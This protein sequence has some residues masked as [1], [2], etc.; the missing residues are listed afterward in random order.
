MLFMALQAFQMVPEL[1]Y[2][3]APHPRWLASELQGWSSVRCS[4]PCI[5]CSAGSGKSSA[6]RLIFR[7]YD[8]TSGAVYM[9]GQNVAD[10][11]QASLRTHMGFVPQ[12]SVLFNDTILHNIRCAPNVTP[13]PSGHCLCQEFAHCRDARGPSAQQ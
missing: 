7:F 8:P 2:L 5:T 1:W 12:D 3:A 6:L 9:D 10:V 11:T 13:A 4:W